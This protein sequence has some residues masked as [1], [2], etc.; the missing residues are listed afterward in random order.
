MQQSRAWVSTVPR[1]GLPR[2]EILRPDGQGIK[3]EQET[4]AYWLIT[5]LCGPGGS[6]WGEIGGKWS[7][8]DPMRSRSAV[9]LPCMVFS[10]VL[11]SGGEGGGNGFS[12]AQSPRDRLTT[13]LTNRRT[14][15]ILRKWGRRP[16]A[17]SPWIDSNS[18]KA[19]LPEDGMGWICVFAPTAGPGVHLQ[20]PSHIV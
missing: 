7:T 14:S 12:R 15:K 6:P 20:R 13:V 10:P 9:P 2:S 18:R 3:R 1:F 11:K 8:A 19:A 17:L 4:E 5:D 16:V